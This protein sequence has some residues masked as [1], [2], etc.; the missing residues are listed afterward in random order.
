MSGARRLIAC[1]AVIALSAC[2]GGG[3]GGGSM[4]TT[5][6]SSVPLIASGTFL[7]GPGG[8]FT[9]QAISFSFN[10]ASFGLGAFAL[11]N[12][13]MSLTADSTGRTRFLTLNIPVP[14]GQ[15]MHT[16]DLAS[17]TAGTGPLGGFIHVRDGTTFPDGRSQHALILDPSLNFSTYGLWVNVQSFNGT[18]GGQGATGVIAF[19]NTTPTAGLPHSGSATYAGRTV[20]A[21]ANGISQSILAGTVNLNVNFGAMTV[22]GTFAIN[23]VTSGTAT[24]W[25]T[26]MMPSTNIASVPFALGPAGTYIGTLTGSLPTGAVTSSTVQGHFTGPQANETVGTWSANDNRTHAVGA[27]GAKRQ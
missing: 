17:A 14:N 16:F 11:N 22:G 12:A 19:G 3:G 24:P 18:T 8:N 27:F 10:G 21:A 23:D 26:L 15:Y 5:P 2:G 1:L 6:S 7:T 20:G 4:Q 13:Q 25:A 9:E